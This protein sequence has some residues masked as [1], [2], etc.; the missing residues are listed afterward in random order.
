M[1]KLVLR[2]TILRN[3]IYHVVGIE[4]NVIQNEPNASIHNT[5]YILGLKHLWLYVKSRDA[6]LTKENSRIQRDL[7]YGTPS[8][9]CLYVGFEVFTAVVLKSIFFVYMFTI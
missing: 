6:N 4:N 7:G 9:H 5:V 8:D 2:K 3:M 1:G